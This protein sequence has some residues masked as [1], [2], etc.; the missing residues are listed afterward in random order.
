MLDGNGWWISVQIFKSISSKMAELW[1]KTCW[2]QPNLPISAIIIFW[3]ILICQKV[4]LG[5]FSCSLRKV[6]IKTCIAVPYHDFFFRGL[7]FFPDDLRWPWPVWCPSWMLKTAWDGHREP[8]YKISTHS[9]NG[10]KRKRNIYTNSLRAYTISSVR[11]RFFEKLKRLRHSFLHVQW[12]C[13]DAH[14][15]LISSIL[16]QAKVF[17]T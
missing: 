15:V 3:P 7:T 1:H 11:L 10:A 13:Y 6:H 9:Y 2:K 16:E 17:K 14:L 5:H 8:T 12:R 4:F